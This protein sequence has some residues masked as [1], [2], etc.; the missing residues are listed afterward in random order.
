MELI[1][2]TDKSRTAPDSEAIFKESLPNTSCTCNSLVD[3]LFGW[4]GSSHFEVCQGYE[5]DSNE[6]SSADFSE[7]SKGSDMLSESNILRALGSYQYDVADCIYGDET[8]SG[9]VA[10]DC[11]KYWVSPCSSDVLHQHENI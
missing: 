1:Q 4:A 3:T 11:L 7:S 8:K 9:E 2:N 6:F 5:A 10:N